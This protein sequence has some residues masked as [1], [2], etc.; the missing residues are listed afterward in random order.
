M[1][2][3]I[4]SGVSLFKGLCSMI[5]SVCAHSLF[6]HQPVA[7][8]ASSR[9]NSGQEAVEPHDHPRQLMDLHEDEHRVIV[10]ALDG[11]AAV[12]LRQTCRAFASEVRTNRSAQT[13]IAR[14][15]AA[16]PIFDEVLEKIREQTRYYPEKEG[17]EKLRAIAPDLSARRIGE[18]VDSVFAGCKFPAETAHKARWLGAIM[19]ALSVQDAQGIADRIGE[20]K[21]SGAGDEAEHEVAR[22]MF[23][24]ELLETM[25]AAPA[26]VYEPFVQLACEN[27]CQMKNDMAFKYM[28]MA[29]CD[30]L[31]RKLLLNDTLPDRY[32]Y[33]SQAFRELPHFSR[34]M[35]NEVWQK[36][37][38]AVQIGL[39]KKNPIRMNIMATLFG[40]SE[41]NR[42]NV[43]NR[44]PAGER[45]QWA[46]LFE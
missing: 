15:K 17:L 24:W 23:V 34:V 32:G 40:Q 45:A 6:F 21:A 43:F 46:S 9:A 39:T 18:I 41:I 22:A 30:R 5:P 26:S 38:T 16:L 19:G 42:Q 36:V 7:A 20:V 25:H 3:S 35:R 33:T 8:I 27:D 37:N 13:R 29:Q 11:F 2:G 1:T 44:I 10:G 31:G 14:A 12:N 28:S 4:E